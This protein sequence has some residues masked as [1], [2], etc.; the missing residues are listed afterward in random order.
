M[1]QRIRQLYR[2]DA[3]AASSMLEDLIAATE[4]AARIRRR[5]AAESPDIP[6]SLLRLSVGPSLR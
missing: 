4:K 1:K 6:P 2:T 3:A 5:W